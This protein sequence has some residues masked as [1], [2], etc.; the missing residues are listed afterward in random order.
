MPVVGWPNVA[1][2]QDYARPLSAF[3]DGLGEAGYVDG[4]N[5]SIEYRW[6]E[7]HEDRLPEL[8]ADLIR[9]GVTV[10]AAT[11]TPAAL[12][13][14]SGDEDNSNHLRNWR[15][16]R[17]A[18]PRRQPQSARWERQWRHSTDRGNSAKR[19]GNATRASSHGA[20]HSRY[21]STQLIP[22]LPRPNRGRWRPRLVH[23]GWNFVSSMPAPNTTSTQSSQT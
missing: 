4:R 1:S 7:H 20:S 18:W 12:A 3:L 13:A 6:A 11:S 15:R 2:H 22:R 5:V 14:K 21:S 23:L 16:P 17:P 10:I 8:V 9:R 19:V